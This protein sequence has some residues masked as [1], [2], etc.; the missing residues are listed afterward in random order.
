MMSA[1]LVKAV[2]SLACLGGLSILVGGCSVN[3]MAG[4]D[5]EYSCTDDGVAKTLDLAQE[6]GETIQPGYTAS[7]EQNAHGCD[8]T[9]RGVYNFALATKP[10]IVARFG[11]RDD[12]NLDVYKGGMRCRAKAG[13]FAL[14]PIREDGVV[15]IEAL[16][17][18]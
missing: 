12:S 18:P 5:F 3:Q 10:T 6:V 17:S 9:T 16:P 15:F 7:M 4:V 2:I 14:Y 11:C 1:A 8:S 13:Y